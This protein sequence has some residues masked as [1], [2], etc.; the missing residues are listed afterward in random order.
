MSAK[1]VKEL[2]KLIDSAPENKVR[3]VLKQIAFEWWAVS[4]TKLDFDKELNSDTLE[5]VTTILHT[6]G[7][8]PKEN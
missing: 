5:Y 6:N 8:C 2:D 7:F 3:E 4:T 1:N